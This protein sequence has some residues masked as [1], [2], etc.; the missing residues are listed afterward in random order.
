M[1]GRRDSALRPLPAPS[2]LSGMLTNSGTSAYRSAKGLA[3]LAKGWCMRL[4]VFEWLILVLAVVLA[5]GGSP[6]QAWDAGGC[7]E[8]GGSVE[9]ALASITAAEVREVVSFLAAPSLEGREAGTPA[10]QQAAQWLAEQVRQLGLAPAGTD[11]DFFQRFGQGMVNVIALLPGC[12][13][14]LADQVI[15]LGAHFDH[16]GY[17]RRREGEP[18]IYPGADDNASGVAGVLELAEACTLVPLK[19]SVLIAFWDGEEKGL[20]GSKHWAQSPTIPRDRLV[21][22]I[23]LDMIGRLRENTL[24]LV[25]VRSGLNWRR[26]FV[27]QNSGELR[28]EFS[29]NLKPDSDHVT[30][31][32]VGV[33]S[34]MFHTGLHEDYHRPTDTADRINCDGAEKVLRYAFCVLYD[35]ATREDLPKFRPEAKSEKPAEQPLEGLIRLGVECRFAGEN[36][37]IEVLKVL[38]GWPAKEAGIEPGDRITAVG[39]TPVGSLQ[40]LVRNVAAAEKSLVLT[41]QKAGSAETRH[42]HVSLRGRPAPLGVIAGVD[43]ADPEV[44]TVYDVVPLSTGERSGLRPGDRIWEF[45]GQPLGKEPVETLAE[46]AALWLKDTSCPT[47]V[48]TVERE[49]RLI[50]VPVAHPGRN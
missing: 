3:N 24:H 2:K 21:A 12:D 41:L 28:L 11:G 18:R 44:V 48:L 32:D 25:G 49:G 42:V 29:W 19:R 36:G 13:P 34:V 14:E 37:G 40:D 27:L 30:F 23:N 39:D 9:S 15:V 8:R 16:I 47:A 50:R 33:P 22:A 46:F 45:N 5:A 6:C 26:L 7:G 10:A 35:L 31:F 1:D 43:P 4:S 38:D 17:G 20:L